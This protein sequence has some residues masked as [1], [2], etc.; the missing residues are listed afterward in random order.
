[1][2]AQGPPQQQPQREPLVPKG[3]VALLVA[4]VLVVAGV[5]LLSG[6]AGGGNEERK[7]ELN[8]KQNANAITNAQAA[9]V[10]RGTPRGVVEDR[11]GPPRSGEQEADEGFG[12][13]TCIYYNV[14]NSRSFDQWQFCFEGAG[15]RGKLTT[16]NR[17]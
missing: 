15:D 9:E 2:E 1:M 10:R 16:K 7:R 12:D 5:V 17:F 4:G 14:K 11:F 3:L 13:D 6:V 8:R